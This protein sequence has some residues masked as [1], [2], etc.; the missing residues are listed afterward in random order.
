MQETASLVLDQKVLVEEV[1]PR[2]AA[3][4]GQ[5]NSNFGGKDLHTEEASDTQGSKGKRRAYAA[6]ARRAAAARLAQ[7][8]AK[9]CFFSAPA[10]EP[11]RRLGL[12]RP[13]RRS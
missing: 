11:Q 10:R 12:D 9:R 7:R 1:C 8:A 5:A 13:Q 3:A 4:L 6:G 2:S